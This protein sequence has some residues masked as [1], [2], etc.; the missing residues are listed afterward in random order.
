MWEF[1]V[2]ITFAVLT[3]H[4][5]LPPSVY[6]LCTQIT[7][8]AFS[9]YLGKLIDKHDRIKVVSSGIVVQ[10][11]CIAIASIFLWLLLEI[12]NHEI[13]DNIFASVYSSLLFIGLL[14]IASI[15]LLGTTIVDLSVERDWVPELFDDEELALM[16]SRMRGIDLSTEILG[17]LI[18]G[19]LLSI[20]QVTP[21]IGFLSIG[22]FNFASFFPQFFLL[23]V[24][25]KKHSFALEK[26]Q[27]SA[28]SQT[29]PSTTSTTATVMQ[30]WNPVVVLKETSSL[31]IKQPVALVAVSWSMLWMTLLSPHGVV[32]TSYLKG[33]GV[34]DWELSVFRS[35]SAGVGLLGTLCF[36]YFSSRFGL[37]AVSQ[38]C[39]TE[40]GVFLI[41]AGVCFTLLHLNIANTIMMQ[42]FM[43]FLVISRFGLHAFGIGELTLLQQGIPEDVRGRVNSFETVLCNLATC[44]IYTA[45]AI[46]SDPNQ[47]I[48]MVWAS[49]I[50]VNIGVLVFAYWNYQWEMKDEEHVHGL[51]GELDDHINYHSKTTKAK[52]Y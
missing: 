27:S 14:I 18:V 25:F 42:L 35:I 51:G 32:L 17:P 20:P 41:F 3:P 31:F 43:V 34:E 48:W 33:Q 10:A 37:K 11:I 13:D 28:K 1:V 40:E 24:V 47:F 6:G 23:L 5:L 30:E 29:S 39:I 49:V 22:A 36:P 19:G 8:A 7:T 4:S 15:E 2:P 52:L 12:P 26:N 45:S 21:E 44:I 38:F 9:S 16:N 46:V 50:S